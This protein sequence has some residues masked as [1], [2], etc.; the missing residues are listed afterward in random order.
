MSFKVDA[1]GLL[2]VSAVE[3]TTQTEA[4]LV[5]KPSFGLSDDE[6]ADMLRSSQE[7]AA[8]DMT[9]RQL[10]EARVE[11]EALLDGLDGALSADAD[12]LTATELDELVAE[13]QRLRAAMGTDDVDAIRAQTQQLGE[14]SLAFAERRMDRSIKSALSGVAIDAL[15]ASS[16]D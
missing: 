10:T 8:G 2:E 1:D 9:V 5:V 7:F 13:Q 16:T 3:E 12:L 11:A 4:S 14:A 15:D 6:V